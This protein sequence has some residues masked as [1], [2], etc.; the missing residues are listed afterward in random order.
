M[1]HLAKRARLL[2]PLIPKAS[3][4]H[5]ATAPESK[6]TKKPTKPSGP[7]YLRRPLGV[8]DPPHVYL[9]SKK[10]VKSQIWDPA[11]RKAKRREI[12]KELSKSYFQDLSQ[13]SQTGGKL[14]IAPETVIRADVRV[15]ARNFANWADRTVHR[16]RYTSL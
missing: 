5:V 12:T 6:A 10:E 1:Q 13:L 14:W 3:T 4:R 9:D 16:K 11:E 15:V 8:Q 2:E 7:P